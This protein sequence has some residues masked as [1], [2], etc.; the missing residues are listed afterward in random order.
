MTPNLDPWVSCESYVPEP[1]EATTDIIRIGEVEGAPGTQVKIPVYISTA[2]PVE[3]VQLVLAYDPDVIGFV[4]DPE[5]IDHALPLS[6]EGTYYEQNF[7]GKTFTIR[8]APGMEPKP[9]AYTP[10]DQNPCIFHGTHPDHRIFTAAFGGHLIYTEFEIP[11]GDDILVAWI[12]VT[13]SPEAEPGTVVDIVPT[14]GTDGAGIGPFGLKNELIY[15]GAARYA[16]ILPQTV[17]GKVG[18]IGDITFFSRGDANGDC[19]VDVSDPI[20]I[21][22]HLF[23]G[24]PPPVCFGAAD[25]DGSRYLDI[26]DPI[27]ILDHLFLGGEWPAGKVACGS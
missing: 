10:S 14:N 26:S 9:Y 25:A 1:A 27:A 4:E 13:I 23:L 12:N 5:R 2:I 19:S 22:G 11:P 20:G 18:V 6:W 8:Q 21:L 15:R 3:A 16:S 24:G 7:F 17:P